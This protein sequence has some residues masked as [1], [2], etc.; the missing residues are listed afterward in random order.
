MIWNSDCEWKVNNERSLSVISLE[1][2]DGTARPMYLT[3]E[4]NDVWY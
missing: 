2:R 1:V 3:L 4:S